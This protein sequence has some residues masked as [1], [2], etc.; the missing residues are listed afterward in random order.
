M[1]IN[2]LVISSFGK[3]TDI[4]ISLDDRV[5]VVTG[6]NEAGKSSIA[7]FIKYMLYGFSGS[8]SRDLSEN[9]KLKYMPWEGD[10][11]SGELHFA[12]D[13]G[14]A[15][16]A[17]R[18][19]AVKSQS[20]VFDENGSPTDITSVGE[21]F[22][23]VSE[24][25]YKKTAFIG[26]SNVSFSDSGEL[27]EAIRNIVYSADEGVDSARAIKK[28]DALRKY[29][30]TKNGKGGEIYELS[31]Q[32]DELTQE[33]EKWQNG[34]KELMSA[35]YNLK[36]ISAKI[37][38]NKEKKAALDKEQINLEAYNAVQKLAKAQALKNDFEQSKLA[39]EKH[40]ATMQNGSFVPDDTLAE[41]LELLLYDISLQSSRSKQLS[42]DVESAKSGV[43]SVYADEKSRIICTRLD[44][45]N[46]DAQ[47]VLDEISL[48]KARAKK[49]FTLAII[50]TLLILTLPLGIFFFI[51]RG[52]INKKLHGL[53]SEFGCESIS[54]LEKSLGSVSSFRS[55]EKSAR[56]ILKNA[57]Q[58][59]V[60]AEN[61]LKE[62]L[63]KLYKYG[64]TCS[65]EVSEN[66][67]LLIES[68]N[69]YLKRVKQ[70]NEK[71]RL[72]KAS[73][74]EAYVAYKTFLSSMDTEALE[75]AAKNYDESIPLRDES[76]IKREIAF[77]T[78]ANE[79]L[80]IKERELEKTAAVLAGTLPKPSEIQSKI[81]SLTALLDELSKKHAALELAI[82]TLE[83]ASESMKKEAAPLIAGESGRLFS[84]ITDGKYK[85]L[86]TDSEMKL[87]FLESDA[88]QA[89]ES[90]YLS[91][92]TL[93][94]AYISLRVALCKFL[95]KEKPVLI[96]DDAFS[97][98][99]DERLNNTLEF[100][101]QL[102]G[103]FQIIILSCHT[104]E[105]EFFLGKGKV[106][107]FEIQR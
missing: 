10:T 42:Q 29:Y 25:C 46:T 50:F 78:Q 14:K 28:L 45:K 72:L 57:A 11:C 85:A 107:D 13:D 47:S 93:D 65:F 34:H 19:T 102:S 75:N 79:A 15:Y 92:G 39:F 23:G 30:L 76:I 69:E 6:K 83:A 106:I 32:I 99:D 105:K 67:T 49:Y 84:S 12:A 80:T 4:G 33:R 20:G 3:L 73:C 24:S 21:H 48:L 82:S 43:E 55:L 64:E 2:K 16:S 63:C 44:E 56:D 52:G 37:A 62:S 101:W 60:E 36:E 96:F 100:L 95:Y 89:R 97:H 22:L 26:E 98:M 17:I 88:A 5:T 1:K 7:S 81:L 31:K 61:A 66:S 54:E 77:Y 70:Y 91:T 87:S 35:E 9:E 51:K 104:R 53:C 27:D 103:E 18:K 58:S 40:F 38:F 86:F 74:N 59:R 8:R 71:C 68:A 41:Q 94:A 90:G